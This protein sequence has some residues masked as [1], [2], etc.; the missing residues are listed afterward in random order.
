MQEEHAKRK[1]AL[2]NEMIA[3]GKAKTDMYEQ[4]KKLCEEK[5]Q[6][7]NLLTPPSLDGADTISQQKQELVE[8]E[9]ELMHQINDIE[10]HVAQIRG[11]L[12][13]LE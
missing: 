3:A 11:I 9:A 4:W 2:I 8:A 7:T 12:F 10:M 6:I 13:D 5:I 1:L